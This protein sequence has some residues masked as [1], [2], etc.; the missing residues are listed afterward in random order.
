MQ[1]PLAPD[2]RSC[3][4]VFG[5]ESTQPYLPLITTGLGAV[6]TVTIQLTFCAPFWPALPTALY[7]PSTPPVVDNAIVP[8]FAPCMS[9]QW[10]VVIDV[11][12]YA[13]SFVSKDGDVPPFETP[14]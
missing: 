13:A 10:Y 12:Q 4:Q 1:N 7:G 3:D 9:F 8:G 2:C 6:E 14:K 11:R 5:S